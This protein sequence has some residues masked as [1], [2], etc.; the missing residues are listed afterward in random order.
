ML[1]LTRR[2]G[3]TIVIDGNI[4]VSVVSME[5]NKIRLGIEAPDHITVDR[6]EIHRRRQS[7]EQ[8]A[9]AKRP[10]RIKNLPSV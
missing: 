9:K 3:E 4:H 6:E 1:V 10:Q 5:G 2:L 8:S 7:F